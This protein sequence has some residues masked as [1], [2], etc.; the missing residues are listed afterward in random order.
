[1]CLSFNRL[2]AKMLLLCFL[3][4][5]IG[6]LAAQSGA[7]SPDDMLR[8]LRTATTS[9][10]KAE[11]LLK[12]SEWWYERGNFQKALKYGEQILAHAPKTADPIAHARGLNQIARTEGRM[13]NLE[14]SVRLARQAIA[15]FE[16]QNAPIDYCY[17]LNT[18]AAYLNTGGQTKEG[19]ELLFC[20]LE[21]EPELRKRQPGLLEKIYGNIS[22]SYIVENDDIAGEAYLHKALAV[23][24]ETHT[25]APTIYH[26][27]SDIKARQGKY[28][29]SIQYE[30]LAL[31]AAEAARDTY[32]IARAS[33]SIADF[34]LK[35]GNLDK[36]REYLDRTEELFA[37]KLAPPFLSRRLLHTRSALCEY[38]KNYSCALQYQL[39]A[40]RMP[41]AQTNGYKT[42]LYT[43]IAGHYL[44]LGKI[45]S[46][47]YYARLI[48]ALI[49]NTPDKT[50]LGEHTLLEAK[51]A[52]QSGEHETA[53]KKI[54]EA[55]DIAEAIG[56]NDIKVNAFKLW[57]ELVRKDSTVIQKSGRLVQK[58]AAF[59]D[60]TSTDF[61]EAVKNFE[62][63]EAT[64]KRDLE[65]SKQR[66]E[67]L[68][69]QQTARKRLN[70]LLGAGLAAFILL[71]IALF[72]RNR[73]LRAQ[74]EAL[75]LEKEARRKTEE[76]K[77]FNYTVSHDLKAPLKNAA[78][79]VEL[80]KA[81]LRDRLD[82][83]AER[84]LH[85]FY[86]QLE[87]MGQMIEGMRAYAEAEQTELQ[88]QT[89]DTAALIEKIIAGLRRNEPERP[90]EIRIE[91]LPA[92]KGDPLMLR[93][94]FTNL[95]S[96]AF[97][98]TR[99]AVPGAIIRVRGGVQGGRV[100]IQVADNG[101]GIPEEGRKRL[102]QLFKSAHDRAQYEGAGAGLMI[103]KRIV[104][105]HGGNIAVESEAGKGAEFT[106]SLPA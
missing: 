21:Y 67:I 96:N 44:A 64:E 60:S 72:F 14:R 1:M 91:P 28:Q 39:A 77:A 33:L 66:I 78:G 25:P 41:V 20:A 30:M 86:G 100:F 40:L 89:I 24:S 63:R 102:F 43:N 73:L 53:L 38:T 57:N 68:E 36:T 51:I 37:K 87:D 23:Q 88:Y 34:T 46:A 99:H 11:T 18:A 85:E 47:E 17:A 26:N 49:K 9:K 10:Q 22:H 7:V 84:Y 6:R 13:G 16:A 12:L 4:S 94:V 82:P 83:E 93:Q 75:E 103:V 71:S 50:R 80:F 54:G 69:Q 92:L 27:L 105:R 56:L 29:E 62:V 32:S 2:S 76:L 3:C 65:I 101:A 79:F 45:D 90:M 42:Y 15:I 74:K 8:D 106:V 35:T 55:V 5:S 48:P 19:R 31:K 58:M 59:T 61:A 97:K 81:Q 98:F 104:E 52:V 70:W 95:L